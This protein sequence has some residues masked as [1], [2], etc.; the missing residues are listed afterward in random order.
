MRGREE[1]VMED[2]ERKSE[3][4]VYNIENVRKSVC[5][6]GEYGY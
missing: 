2:R 4:I 6:R 1:N 5:A 3:R